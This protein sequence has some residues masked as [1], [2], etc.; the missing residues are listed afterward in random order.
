MATLSK[1][2]AT[3]SPDTP[4]AVAPDS[5]QMILETAARL[6]R[7]DGYAATTL[8]AIA[9]DC[10][11][12]AGSIYYHFASKDV[13]VAEVLD[14]GVRRVFDA[15]KQAVDALPPG[16]GLADTLRCA[17]ETHLRALLL[18]HDFTSANIRILGQVPLPVREAHRALRRRYERYWVTLLERFAATRRH[19]RHQRPEPHR[20]FSVRRD[21]LGHRVV[22]RAQIAAGCGGGRTGRPGGPWPAQ[23]RQHH[24]PA[25]AHRI[26]M[27]ATSK[28]NIRSAAFK[29]NQQSYSGML[30]TLRERMAWAVRGGG[31]KLVQRHIARGK[32]PVR[33]RIDLLLDVGSPF[34]EIA[35][36]AGWGLY[37]NE[38]PSAGAVAGIGIVEGQHCM[39][40]ANDATVKG[41]S[42]FKETVR[43]HVRAQEIALQNRL[44]CV[45][46]VDL[47]AAPSCPNKTRC[48]PTGAISAPPSSTSAA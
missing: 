15:V 44:P 16:T 10:D 40:I 25:K 21:E 23:P 13:I 5:R 1:R 43:K 12:K 8:R 2:T 39:V 19:S 35:P 26:D 11:M 27:S 22:R 18:A 47:C 30:A 29:N 45:Y 17:I 34:L 41:G 42:F 37:N 20:V 36:L 14:I 28:I 6:F 48:S 32:L 31:D 3:A 46:L 38:V 33:E 4:E 24:R 7:R 9:A